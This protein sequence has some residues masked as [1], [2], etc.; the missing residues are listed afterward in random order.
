MPLG[1]PR[2][3]RGNMS[4]DFRGEGRSHGKG[5]GVETGDERAEKS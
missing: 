4:E 1:E 3:Q 2:R 5:G